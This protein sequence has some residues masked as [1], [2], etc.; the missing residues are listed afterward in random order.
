MWWLQAAF[1]V[2]LLPKAWGQTDA[3]EFSWPGITDQ[4]AVSDFY[5]HLGTMLIVADVRPHMEWRVATIQSVLC[6]SPRQPSRLNR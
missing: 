1:A 3:F 6:V 5:R 4:C 2:A